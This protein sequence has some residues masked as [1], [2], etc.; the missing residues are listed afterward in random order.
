[1]HEASRLIAVEEIVV[2]LLKLNP[3]ALDHIIEGS[4]EKPRFADDMCETAEGREY[5]EVRTYAWHAKHQLLTRAKYPEGLL[6][7]DDFEF[8]EDRI[9]LPRLTGT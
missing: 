4:V 3:A 8:D 9:E 1:V 5:K 6:A 7:E 2:E